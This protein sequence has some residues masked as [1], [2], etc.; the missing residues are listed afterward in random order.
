MT[1]E[2]DAY[3][4]AMEFLYGRLNYERL[5]LPRSSEGL[6]LGRMRR[7]MRKL[8][9][10]QKSYRIIHVAGTKGKGST[11][12]ILGA[13]LA[14]S[15]YRTGLFSSPH[16]H[17]LEER[18]LINGSEIKPDDLV[19]LVKEIQPVVELMDSQSGCDQ[20]LTFFEITTALGLLYFQRESCEIVVLEVGMGGRL[21]STNI[22][23]PDVAVLTSISLDHT[24]QL[25]STT[26]EIAREKAGILKRGGQAVSGVTDPQAMA[27][28]QDVADSRGSQL[29]RIG[30]DYRF[31]ANSPVRPIARPTASSLRT[32]TWVSDWGEIPCPLIGPHQIEN[33]A[34]AMAV[35]DLMEERGLKL[36]REKIK[37]AWRRLQ[38][39][40]RVEIMRDQPLVVIDGAHNEASAAALASTI[41]ENFPASLGVKVL[42]FGTTR[43]KDLE[44]QLRHLVPLFDRIIVTQY[45]LNPRA[46]PLDETA[47][48]IN[49]IKGSN[50]A[51]PMIE[52]APEKAIELAIELAGR[53]G[54][55]VVT[56]SLFLAAEVRSILMN[57]HNSLRN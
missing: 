9:D 30:R 5:G 52:P 4:Q 43:E 45:H 2:T 34:L 36:H 16:L 21:D 32:V 25:G 13:A 57:P 29:L 50:T 49:K 40:A 35:L 28:I 44:G 18:Y 8:G 48:A 51:E 37:E 27:V 11:C 39:P 22:V 12:T 54:L 23:R 1:R 24:R 47:L 10:P 26:A 20:K 41:Q 14:A 53:T 46:R 33:S 38:M 6:G 19:K 17:H 42:V 56:G 7:L 15:G 31:S 3:A 55:A